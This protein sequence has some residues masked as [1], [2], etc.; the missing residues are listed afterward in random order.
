MDNIDNKIDE[1]KFEDY[2]L[3]YDDFRT[4]F[5]PMILKEMEKREYMLEVC[6]FGLSQIVEA[7]INMYVSEE[8]T[9]QYLKDECT[10]IIQS[11][12]KKSDEIKSEI[13]ESSESVE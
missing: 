12:L 5:T 3:Q 2:V 6:V 1:I 4:E 10:H 8:K 7:M 9:N 13:K 11:E